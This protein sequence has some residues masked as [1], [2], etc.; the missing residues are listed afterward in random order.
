[1]TRVKNV[2]I[3]FVPLI[4]DMWKIRVFKV[5]NSTGEYMESVEVSVK[6]IHL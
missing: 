3:K 6:I 5:F 4:N 2:R 1:M